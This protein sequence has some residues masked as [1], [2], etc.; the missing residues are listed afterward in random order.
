MNTAAAVLN[1]NPTN[2]SPTVMDTFDVA[3]QSKVNARRARRLFRKAFGKTPTRRW[4][5]PT[6]EGLVLAQAIVE[7]QKAIG[8]A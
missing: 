7:Q 3:A 8:R 6:N 1:T 4:F 2:N 5:F